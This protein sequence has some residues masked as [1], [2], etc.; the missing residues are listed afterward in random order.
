MINS[1]TITKKFVIKKKILT[2]KFSNLTRTLNERSLNVTSSNIEVYAFLSFSNALPMS[3]ADFPRIISA[4]SLNNVTHC[5][6]V[7]SVRNP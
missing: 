7:L 6:P 5:E 3:L 1:Q 2:P 4:D